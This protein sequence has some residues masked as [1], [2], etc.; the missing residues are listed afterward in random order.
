MWFLLIVG[1]VGEPLLQDELGCDNTK[2][3]HSFL[4]FFYYFDCV[5]VVFKTK[6]LK[7][8]IK[9]ETL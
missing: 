3:I 8:K 5:N 7:I 6:I 2:F 4:V 1:D 9:M